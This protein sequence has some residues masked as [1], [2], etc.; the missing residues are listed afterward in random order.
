MCVHTHALSLAI[1]GLVHGHVQNSQSTGSMQDHGHCHLGMTFLRKTANRIA[2]P[3]WLQGQTQSSMYMYTLP[4][5]EHSLL[6]TSQEISL[7]LRE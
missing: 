2:Y 5:A 6:T 3:H 1:Q 7:E 4:S